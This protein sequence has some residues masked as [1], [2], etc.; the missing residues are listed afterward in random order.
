MQ[1]DEAVEDFKKRIENYKKTY[2]TVIVGRWR[3]S[4]LCFLKN[5]SQSYA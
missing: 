5:E 4:A 1:S 2:E 3:V